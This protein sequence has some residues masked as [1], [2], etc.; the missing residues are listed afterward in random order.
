MQRAK[1]RKVRALKR[2]CVASQTALESAP[3]DVTK[4]EMQADYSKNAVKLKSAEKQLKDFCKQTG[5]RND[6]FR[7]QVD[8]FGR[9]QAQKAVWANKKVQKDLTSFQDN[10]IMSEA[11]NGKNN[12]NPKNLN[13]NSKI[14]SAFK[15]IEGEHTW[16]EDAQATNPNYVTGKREYT[17]NCQRCVCAYEMRRRG[18]NVIAKPRLPDAIDRMPNMD[19]TGWPSVFKN[20]QLLKI[21]SKSPLKLDCQHIG[22]MHK[23]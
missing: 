8:G 20:Y 2:Q 4:S 15:R 23:M 5:R 22:Q 21:E 7:T 19:S 14:L 13:E 9:S 12:S 11:T 16:Q 6:T 17:A 3:D 18:Y 10:G 1:E